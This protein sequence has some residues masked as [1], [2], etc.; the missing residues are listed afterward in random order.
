M[1]IEVK[2][3]TKT[4]GSQNAVDDIS[5]SVG[6]SEV[7]GFLGPNG[8]GKTTTM[9]ILTCFIPPS[10]G[11]AY[12][13]GFD[14]AKHPIEIR[15]QIGYLPEHNPL[16]LDMYVREYLAFVARVHNIKKGAKERVEEMIERTGLQRERN[17]KIGQLSK[18]Y[19]QRVGLASAIIHNPKVLILD[20]PTTG[21]DPN[22]LAEIR[23]LIRE[24]GKEKTLLFSTHIMQEVE[25]VCDR[26]IIIDKGKIVANDPI[27]QL[28][29]RMSG[30]LVYRIEFLQQ[31]NAAFLNDQLEALT[32][33]EKVVTVSDNVFDC[34][35]KGEED[36]RPDLFR[37]AVDKG[38]T[39]IGMQRESRSLED[40]F[41]KLTQTANV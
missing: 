23:E 6:D 29:N 36:I 4:Y 27:K 19:R 34:V 15:E 10:E 37:F 26:V 5:F 14:T 18:G 41:K 40:V 1:S 31:N 11:E 12:V 3:I 7:V 38:H 13:S 39:L 32:F 28:Q 24:L 30:S 8:A 9:K 22:Q 21:L 33:I 16:Y 20:E 17:K 35:A 2:N 25:A